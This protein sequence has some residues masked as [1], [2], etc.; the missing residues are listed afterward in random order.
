MA[1]A[2]IWFY[3]FGTNLD[4]GPARKRLVT[5]GK[6]EA[7]FE[8]AGDSLLVRAPGFGDVYTNDA[9]D[10]VAMAAAFP[11]SGTVVDTAGAPIA[12]AI[13]SVSNEVSNLLEKRTQGVRRASNS[14]EPPN[15]STLSE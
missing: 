3:P 13:V 9:I 14:T 12:D 1:G 7:T 11:F 6:G 8:R 2:T 15:A 5:D 10:T 4:S